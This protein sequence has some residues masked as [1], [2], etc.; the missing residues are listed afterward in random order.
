MIYTVLW[1]YAYRYIILYI[2]IIG[3]CAYYGQLT[4]G[5]CSYNQPKWKNVNR[6]V[7]IYYRESYRLEEF[8][9]YIMVVNISRTN[10]YG[11]VLTII[12]ILSY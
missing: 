2:F 8:V 12:G 6:V 5:K 11:G 1:T 3:T 10:L 7:G 4:V 9:N